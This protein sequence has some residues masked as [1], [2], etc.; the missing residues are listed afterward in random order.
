MSKNDFA[1][2][3][4]ANNQLKKDDFRNFEPLFEI[5]NNIIKDS[6]DIQDEIVEETT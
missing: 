3:I 1:N 2:E 5:I 6:N 4:K